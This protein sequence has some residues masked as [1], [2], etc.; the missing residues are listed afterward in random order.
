[1][2][3]FKPRTTVETREPAVLVEAG[4]EPGTYR[5]RL[6]V[7]NGR[8]VESLPSELTITVSKPTRGLANEEPGG[9]GTP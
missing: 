4:L 9:G 1:M 8:G 2:P 5:F 7:V 6:V 3:V